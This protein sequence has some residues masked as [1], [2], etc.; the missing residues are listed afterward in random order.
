MA[1]QSAPAP[2]VV[3]F[4]TTPRAGQH[5]R[6]TIDLQAV[7]QMRLEAA[8]E[9]T[10][11]ERAKISAAAERMSQMGAMKMAT[12][13]EQT[14]KVGQPDR[15]G[16]LPLTVAVNT[17]GGSMEVGGKAVP[18]PNAKATNISYAG[19]FNPQDFGFEMQKVAGMP[20]EMEAF[21]QTQGKSVVA[22]ALQ[23]FKA[24]S[25]RPLKVGDSVDVPLAMA[26]PVPMP[27]GAGA[28]Q[29]VARYTLAR[30]ERGVAHFDLTMDLDMDV[31]APLPTPNAAAAASA[32]SA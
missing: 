26:L 12:Q 13:M 15:D 2:A 31:T 21:M 30:V 19:R 9:A 8:P 4:D 24:L 16:W 29:G 28:M 22:E 11:E 7:M 32:A 3:S 23:L 20:P 14:L 18:L 6:Q 1:A 5:Q 27:G 25:Q 10:E 17:K